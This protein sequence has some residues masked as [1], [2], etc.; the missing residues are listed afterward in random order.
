MYVSHIRIMGML[1]ML[2]IIDLF[3]LLISRNCQNLDELM[4]YNK[5]SDKTKEKSSVKIKAYSESL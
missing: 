2:Y 4:K 5:N 1:H 3:Y